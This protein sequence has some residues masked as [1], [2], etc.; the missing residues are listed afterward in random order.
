[1]A[2]C[3]GYTVPN[4]VPV[5]YHVLF[6]AIIEIVAY[7]F[8]T[9]RTLVDGH[10]VF[11]QNTHALTNFCGNISHI[12]C[13]HRRFDRRLSDHPTLVFPELFA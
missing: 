3:L 8:H 2:G 9:G 7:Q 12:Y 13:V 11:A 1:M 4:F 5:V 10:V 6:Q